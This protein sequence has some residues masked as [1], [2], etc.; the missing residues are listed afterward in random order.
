MS[1]ER[2]QQVKQLFQSALELEPEKRA[3]F[4]A[5]ACA[6]D[7]DLRAEVE[8]LLA[9]HEGA[10]NFIEMPALAEM[11]TLPLEE[12]AD[13]MVGQRIGPYKLIR[14]IGHGGM[15]KVYLAVRA[16]EEFQKRVAIKLVKRGMETDFILRRFR[17]ERQIL[18]SL[19]HPNIARLLDGGTTEDGLP[20]FVME[21]IEGQ[22]LVEYC[23]QR[24]L[25][26]TERLKLFR[27]ICSAVHYAHQ[28]LVI[29][30]DLKP[31]NILVTAE[32]VV[33]LL[34]F[35]I[36]K[37]LNPDL[38]AAT[39]APTATAMRLMTPEYA[40]PEQV[41]G[42]AVTTASDVYSL[43][44][45]LYELLTGHRP[46]RVTSSA[47]HEITRIICE[48]EPK[49]PSTAISCIEVVLGPDGTVQKQLT[50]EE[51]S[52]NREG[53]PEK[54]RRRLQGDLDNIVL[55]AMRK[56]PQRRYSSVE[57]FSEDIRRHL[58]GLPV[59]ARKDTF[60]YRA[61]KFV[62]RHKAGVAAAVLF[63]ITLLIGIVATAWQASVANRERARAERRFN[64]VRKLANSFLFEFH[65]AIE[66][67]P[68]S[69]PARALVVRR[70]LEYLDSLAQEASSDL[71]LQRELATAYE[72]VG[73]I[74][75]NPY[76]ANLGETA[77]ALES[78]RK[79][80]A[81]RQSLA[82]T[83][84]AKVEIKRELAG[85]YDRI[86]DMLQLTHHLAEALAHYRQALQL[87]QELA[88]QQPDN[89]SIQRELAGSYEL[90]GDVLVKNGDG[91]GALENFR[92]FFRIAQSLAAREPT[93]LHRRYLALSYG[94][95]STG[96]AMIGEWAAAIERARQSLEMLRQLAESEPNNARA[97]RELASGYNRLGD[98]LWSIKDLPKALENYREALKLSER[99]SSTDPL[100][101]QY[102]HDLARSYSNV[103]Y[104]LAQLGDETA[105]VK[106][107]REALQ[108]LE[109]LSEADPNNASVQ[110]DL[111]A[112][113][114]Y[115]G[116]VYS[117]LASKAS[118]PTSKQIEHWQA[119]RSWYQRSLKLTL[120][121]RDRGLLRSSD[122]GEA[123]RLTSLID[124]CDQTLMKLKGSPQRMKG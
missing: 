104:V 81:I 116:D 93:S 98:L 52:K 11:P 102:R 24:K 106:D 58:E 51:V 42:L 27:T 112:C 40:S 108:V 9:S 103:G 111:A 105:A 69:T 37:I 121:I 120:Q 26:T 65:E 73:D 57:Q 76:L 107:Y 7:D 123:D 97:Q 28:N 18:A 66:R 92:Q 67:L 25:S 90:I 22:P 34:D 117:F 115:F 71:S 17:N 124:K 99:L 43:G 46:Y 118:L 3:A 2:Y 36:A 30:R 79:A 68:G 70:A 77:G 62:K 74:Q 75:G 110:R 6:R 109:A 89:L 78:Y 101:Q 21:Y 100:N 119:A 87:R 31:S 23:D 44:V 45:V 56:E 113:Y 4:L 29:H 114:A 59:I 53:Q 72:R 15:G 80:L 35:G 61:G 63:F 1:P 48:E 122:A 38:S 50:P 54:L 39:I 32:G 8:S 16:D 47:L 41:R 14:E 5:E 60:G 85:S 95:L 33:K 82:A 19:D 96:L 64:D 55:M 10:E 49:K 20:Y 94:K 13:S 91:S 86:G 83:E 12:V 84:P 88:L